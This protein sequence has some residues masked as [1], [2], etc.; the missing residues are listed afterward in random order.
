MAKHAGCHAVAWQSRLNVHP[1]LCVKQGQEYG[2]TDVF[3]MLSMGG[4]NSQLEYAVLY[5]PITILLKTEL[6]MAPVAGT[7]AQWA[8]SVLP[9]HTPTA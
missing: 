4:G 6:Y 1:G 5:M 3:L 8:T 2:L 9:K 7:G